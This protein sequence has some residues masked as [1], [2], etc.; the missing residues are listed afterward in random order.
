MEGNVAHRHHDGREV[1]EGC[2]V[3]L[4]ITDLQKVVE[5][6]GRRGVSRRRVHPQGYDIV[7]ERVVDPFGQLVVEGAHVREDRGYQSR[8][9]PAGEDE[10]LNASAILAV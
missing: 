3:S 2:P 7:R 6:A 1:N 10:G 5:R 8:V 9:E 4:R